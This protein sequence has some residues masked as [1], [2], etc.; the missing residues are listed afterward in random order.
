MNDTL[1]ELL[2]KVTLYDLIW[3]LILVSFAVGVVVVQRKKI[4][5]VL[6]KWRKT[7][8]EEEDFH[9][10]VYELKESIE[11]LSKEVKENQQNRDQKFSEVRK[12]LNTQSQNIMELKNT[13]LKIQEKN[14]ET[15][16]AE[17]KEKI[18]RIY[19]ECTHE[20]VCTEGQFESLKDLIEQYEKHGGDNSFV[21]TTVQPEMYKWKVVKEVRRVSRAEDKEEE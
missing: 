16:R 11:N 20:Q 1:L 12:E 10:L 19:R 4:S 17:I 7:K 15:K 13:V 3:A 21:H 2:T 5:K 9:S 14:S 8:N 18:E 6:D